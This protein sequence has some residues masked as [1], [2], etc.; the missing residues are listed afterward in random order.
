MAGIAGATQIQFMFEFRTIGTALITDRILNCAIVYQ[1][2][3]TDYHYQ[4]SVG[5]TNLTT[6]LFAWRMAQAWGS[7][8]P[9]MRVNIYEATSGSLLFTDNTLSPSQGTFYKSYNNGV[10]LQ[11]YDTND[12]SNTGSYIYYQPSSLGDNIK[13][14]ANFL[15]Y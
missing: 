15:Q 9:T 14:Q 5:Q 4:P 3:S 6:K 13:V 7:T 10:S 12:M 11:A 8:V 1:D 2:T